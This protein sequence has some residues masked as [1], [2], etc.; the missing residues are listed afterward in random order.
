MMTKAHDI[1]NAEINDIATYRKL[2]CSGSRLLIVVG[3]VQEDSSSESDDDDDDDLDRYV[4]P[5]PITINSIRI[6]L[7]WRLHSFN[8]D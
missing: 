7:F 3:R 8:S 6:T 2:C 4:Q 5:R 1:A